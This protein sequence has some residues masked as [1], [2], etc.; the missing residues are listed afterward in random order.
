MSVADCSVLALE[1]EW[2]SQRPLSGGAA[3]RGVQGDGDDD[4]EGEEDIADGEEEDAEAEAEGE[5]EEEVC[6]QARLAPSRS[7]HLTSSCD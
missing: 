4:D 7:S 6:T 3:D 2:S 1:A 5:S